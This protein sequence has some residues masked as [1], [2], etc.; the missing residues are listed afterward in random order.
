M[1]ADSCHRAPKDEF[2]FLRGIKCNRE[3]PPA[4]ILS[5]GFLPSVCQMSVCTDAI[6]SIIIQG[7]GH[8]SYQQISSRPD[9]KVYRGMSSNPPPHPRRD[10]RSSIQHTTYAQTLQTGDDVQHSAGVTS[11]PRRHREEEEE[12]GGK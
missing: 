11:D 5:G 1:A 8:L 7:P 12:E 4:V 6:P 2:S 9:G 3:K 10:N